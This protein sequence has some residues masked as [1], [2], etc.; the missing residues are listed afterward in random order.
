MRIAFSGRS[1]D[2]DCQPDA[3]CGRGHSCCPRCRRCAS[4][5]SR[6]W[7]FPRSS[8]PRTSSRDSRLRPVALSPTRPSPFSPPRA[9]PGRSIQTTTTKADP[10]SF[11][12]MA[13]SVAD[14]HCGWEAADHHTDAILA[15]RTKARPASSSILPSR[16]TPPS[17]VVPFRWSSSMASPSPP[18]FGRTS[19]LS[20]YRAAIA[21]S[22]TVTRLEHAPPHS[23]TVPSD[24]YGRGYSDAPDV[25]YDVSLHTTQLALL[26]QHI[27]WDDAFLVG[28]SM[29]RIQLVV[30]DPE[31]WP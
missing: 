11:S 4:W 17:H 8:L 23:L 21:F 28:L 25:T 24:L 12:H 26:M 10:M 7:L 3:C 18:L 14:R 31:R 29:V 30:S 19:H 6:S 16:Y 27:R 5:S 9:H 13:A 20:S 2:S 22:S 15:H 1:C